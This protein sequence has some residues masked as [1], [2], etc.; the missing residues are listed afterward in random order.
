M[1][2]EMCGIGSPYRLGNI[3]DDDSAVRISVVHRSKRLVPLLSSCIPYLKL[4]SG[5]FIQ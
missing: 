5:V 3:V 4:D 1:L 2:V